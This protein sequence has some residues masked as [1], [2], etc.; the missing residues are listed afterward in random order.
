MHIRQLCRVIFFALIVLLPLVRA[1]LRQH[2]T[3]RPK[4]PRECGTAPFKLL[5][6]R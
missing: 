2:P 4:L 6:V 3:R 5:P 1:V